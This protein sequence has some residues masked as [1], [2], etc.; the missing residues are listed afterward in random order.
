LPSAGL[1]PTPILSGNAGVKDEEQEQLGKNGGEQKASPSKKESAAK[2][3]KKLFKLMS[4]EKNSGRGDLFVSPTG[5]I[6]FGKAKLKQVFGSADATQVVV[7]KER[8]TYEKVES[9]QDF[10]SVKAGQVSV[11]DGNTII[12]IQGGPGSPEGEEDDKK[13]K[14]K[15]SYLEVVST[16]HPRGE[17][18]LPEFE[19]DE[20][21]RHLDELKKSRLLVVNCFDDD[22]ADASASALVEA[23]DAEGG[24]QKFYLDCDRNELEDSELTI[25]LFAN[26]L[27][28]TPEPS[29]VLVDASGKRGKFFLESLLGKK[30][31]A[32]NLSDYLLSNKLWLICRGNSSHMHKLVTEDREPFFFPRWEIDCLPKLLKHHFPE[33]HQ[34][35]KASIERQ[36]A[37]GSWAAEEEAFCSQVRELIRSGQ[38]EEEVSKIEQ[39]DSPVQEETDARG[40]FI[41]SFFKGGDSVK[42]TVLYVAAYFP[43]LNP[44]EFNRVVAA[45]L[46][47]LTTK[48][49]VPAPKATQAV[50]AEMPD[51]ARAEHPPGEEAAAAFVWEEQE[52]LRHWQDG[53]DEILTECRLEIVIDKD[54]AR[55]FDFADPATRQDLRTYLE[56]E[57]GF[58]LKKQFSRIQNLGLLFDRSLNVNE[59]V[60]TVAVNMALESP[61]TF[62]RDWLFDIVTP[63]SPLLEKA[64]GEELSPG[65]PAYKPSLPGN[66]EAAMRIVYSTVAR[67]VRKM[68]EHPHLEKTINDFFTQLMVSGQHEAVLEIVRRLHTTQQLELK[69]IRQLFDQGVETIRLKNYFALYDRVRQRDAGVYEVLQALESWLPER[70][71]NPLFYSPSNQYALRLIFDYC[72]DTTSEFDSKFYGSWPCRY[73]LLATPG[74]KSPE[75]GRAAQSNLSLLT[76]WLFHPGLKE[77]LT[78]E[79]DEGSSESLNISLGALLAEWAVILLGSDVAV[80]AGNGHGA[81]D[82]APRPETEAVFDLLL[83]KVVS[84]TT[85]AQQKDLIDCWTELAD[86]F[87]WHINALEMQSGT[88]RRRLSRRRNWVRYLIKRF[89][90]LRRQAD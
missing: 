26:P 18:E 33:R 39:G 90:I 9:R 42:D 69:W 14:V 77:V 27:T 54:S 45:L 11:G 83:R 84:V 23:L 10:G 37:K 89:K 30:Q 48:V 2:D 76:N 22:L 55:R 1:K 61:E 59:G 71:R 60:A 5:K 80:G 15:R 3:E 41:R 8:I 58:Y 38:L 70:D 75:G 35:L 44:H 20:L 28:D 72:L 7:G 88:P 13:K 62:G 17:L 50:A 53:A 46:E 63:L 85:P 86:Y 21:P 56:T 87:L 34:S 32:L 4:A 73:P 81:R 19:F 31:T 66:V 52:L 6:E 16:L 82:A 57:K 25:E 51:K 29:V 49:A 12:T 65:D 68:L 43:D 47:G 24:W 64:R 74:L 36:R 40:S 78:D 67:L 79:E